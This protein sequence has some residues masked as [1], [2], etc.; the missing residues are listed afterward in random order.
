MQY[1]S[2]V[3]KCH[4]TGFEHS[5]AGFGHPKAGFEH[6]KTAFLGTK[7]TICFFAC[8]HKL[9]KNLFLVPHSNRI[10]PTAVAGKADSVSFMYGMF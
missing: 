1:Y 3:L 4:F 9:S 2:V 6:P 10:S 5:K 7:P 8:N